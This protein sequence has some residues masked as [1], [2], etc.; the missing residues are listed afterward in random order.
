MFKFN[1]IPSYIQRDMRVVSDFFYPPT[2]FTGV[3]NLYVPQ[4]EYQVSE[5]TVMLIQNNPQ[6]CVIP[7]YGQYTQV[8]KDDINKLKL[9]KLT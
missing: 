9:V 6:I 1:T 3:R 4:I 8:Q 5:G 7:H 2:Y